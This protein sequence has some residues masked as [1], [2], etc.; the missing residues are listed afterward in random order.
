[1]NIELLENMIEDMMQEISIRLLIFPP[2]MDGC[3]EPKHD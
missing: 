1:M 2:E 3:M